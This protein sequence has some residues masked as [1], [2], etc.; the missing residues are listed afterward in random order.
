MSV[1]VLFGV[2]TVVLMATQ[3]QDYFCFRLW[4]VCFIPP[5]VLIDM[6]RL[7]HQLLS[8]SQAAA[9]NNTSQR[10]V[11]STEGVR[12]RSF[13]RLVKNRTSVEVRGNKEVLGIFPFV[14]MHQ[15]TWFVQ[16]K[17][18]CI[19]SSCRQL[20]KRFRKTSDF[21]SIVHRHMTKIH[22]IS[23]AC[24][25]HIFPIISIPRHA[26]E[27]KELYVVPNNSRQ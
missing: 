22:N 1:F 16:G 13:P 18:S 24:K 7:Y 11:F 23:G 26:V 10:D 19:R 8:Q 20:Y 14:W 27:Y 17:R 5:T 15:S 9:P 25:E 12:K 21:Q 2:Q 4:I 6:E 3:F